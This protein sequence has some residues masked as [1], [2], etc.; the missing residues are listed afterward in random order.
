MT[1]TA[2][3]SQSMPLALVIVAL[4]EP[5]VT[6]HGVLAFWMEQDLGLVGHIRT[7]LCNIQFE[8]NWYQS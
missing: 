4:M 1:I 5:E 8:Q 7:L 2:A 6:L 3:L